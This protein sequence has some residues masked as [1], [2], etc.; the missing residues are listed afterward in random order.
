MY[1]Y[2]TYGS[3]AYGGLLGEIS[4]KTVTRKD[5]TILLTVANK[6]LNVLKSKQG[7]IQLGTKK[8]DNNIL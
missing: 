4:V 3:I 6:A 2:S 5:K 8:K 7:K 1:G